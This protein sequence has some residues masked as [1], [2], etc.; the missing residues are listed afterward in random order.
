MFRFAKAIEPRFEE[1]SGYK[2]KRSRASIWWTEDVLRQN[3]WVSWTPGVEGNT[4]LFR[5]LI[6]RDKVML[7]L[8]AGNKNTRGWSRTFYDTLNGH[9]PA[10]MSWHIWGVT[11][12]GRD[13]SEVPG[14]ALLG[15][16]R[17]LEEVQTHHAAEQFVMETIE[18]LLPGFQLFM[19]SEQ[20]TGGGTEALGTEADGSL[21]ALYSEFLAE[22][23]FPNAGDRLSLIHISEPTRPY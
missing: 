22:T 14:S 19:E 17:T 9:E 15:A 12:A 13:P 20:G 21:G 5:L 4:P 11:Q 23:G 8:T 2:L 7:G 6:E 18:G 3:I 1:I 10:G 16:T